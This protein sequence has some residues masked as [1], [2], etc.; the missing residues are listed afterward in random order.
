MTEQIFYDGDVGIGIK[1]PSGKLEI[2][3]TGTDYKMKFGG[4]GGDTRHISTNGEMVLNSM[5]GLSLRNISDYGDLSNGTNLLKVDSTGKIEIGNGSS[6]DSLLTVNGDVD[7]GASKS[8]L[9]AY[10]IDGQHDR[11]VGDLRLQY[12]TGRDVQ[13]GSND[14]HSNLN[15]YGDV[16]SEGYFRTTTQVAFSAYLTSDI[17]GDQSPLKME[18]T[19]LNEGDGFDVDTS[20]FTAP[21]EGVY[22]FAMNAYCKTPKVT[23]NLIINNA[24][25]DLRNKEGGELLMATENVA[26]SRTFI[27]RLN[28]K[29]QVWVSQG[30]SE[31]S[32]CEKSRSGFDGCL[33]SAGW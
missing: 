20:K 21:I 3:E 26:Y 19:Y 6:T 30:G 28:E 10:Q 18:K 12:N 25:M 1:S 15:V 23:W 16:K 24:L 11:G 9:K 13:V 5:N 14:S 17:K 2:G 4:M 7:L 32:Y 33:L 27:V 8:T 22:L 29:A 31:D